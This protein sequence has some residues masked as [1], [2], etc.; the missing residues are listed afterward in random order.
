MATNI[1]VSEPEIAVSDVFQRVFWSDIEADPFRVEVWYR[2]MGPRPSD[3]FVDAV[4]TYQDVRFGEARDGGWESIVRLTGDRL[5][6]SEAL[7]VSEDAGLVLMGMGA[8]LTMSDETWRP[9]DGVFDREVLVQPGTFSN[10]EGGFGFLG[11]VNQYTTEWTLSPEIT[12][13]IGY[14]Y[15]GVPSD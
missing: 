3:P 14:S 4:I 10:I 7:G 11:A 15:P 8:R 12:E 1:Q 5:L 9:P 2:F 6:V 13:R